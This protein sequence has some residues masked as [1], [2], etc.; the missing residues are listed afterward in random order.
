VN[1]EDRSMEPIVLEERCN[2]AGV[3][4]L[5]ER[6]LRAMEASGEC[7]IV[8]SNVRVVDAATLQLL[9]SAQLTAANRGITLRCEAPS[10]E[11]RNAARLVGLHAALA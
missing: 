4:A 11:L 1:I 3:E 2:I 6:L 5:R 10:E 7:T 8:C 9:V